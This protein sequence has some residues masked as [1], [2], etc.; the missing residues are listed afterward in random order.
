[1]K[2]LKLFMVCITVA[3][4]AIV[5]LTSCQS[6]N[7]IGSGDVGRHYEYNFTVTRSGV[8][9]PHASVIVLFSNDSDT[10][11]TCGAN[12]SVALSVG[13]PVH[14]VT[15]ASLGVSGTLDSIQPG[16]VI[17]PV[18][19]VPIIDTSAAG[20]LLATYVFGVYDTDGNGD[21][22]F[23]YQYTFQYFY[24]SSWLPGWPYGNPN[25]NTWTRWT[26]TDFPA[27]WKGMKLLVPRRYQYY[28]QVVYGFSISRALFLVSAS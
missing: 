3:L 21:V 2:L 1:M 18:A 25:P 17:I 28:H 20:K 12:G 23:R 27:P 26:L 16:A 9:I 11:L 5:I 8:P 22:R 4:I 13:L 15:G 24:C 10:L 7:P 6:R 14:V 19:E